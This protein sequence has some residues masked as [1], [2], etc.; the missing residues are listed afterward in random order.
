MM[1]YELK[2]AVVQK[3]PKNVEQKKMLNKHMNIKGINFGIIMVN[4]SNGCQKKDISIE[5]LDSLR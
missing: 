2:A 3:C 1:C 5:E 4:F